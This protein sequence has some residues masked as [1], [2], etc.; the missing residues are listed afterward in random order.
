MTN[1][2]YNTD[3]LS[4]ETIR[5]FMVDAIMSCYN[6]TCQTIVVAQRQVTKDLFVKQ[7]IDDALDSEYMLYVVDRFAHGN[8]VFKKEQCEYEICLTY[9]SNFLYVF[10]NEENF[11]KL[12]NKYDLKLRE[13][14]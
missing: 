6:L 4:E 2:F 5:S 10:V 13:W 11:N 8:G 7:Y 12:V 3:N 9:N 14:K 1:G